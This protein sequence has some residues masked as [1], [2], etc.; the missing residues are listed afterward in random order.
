M[1][2]GDTVATRSRPTITQVEALGLDK[3]GL[4]QVF[5]P[6]Q[7]ENVYTNNWTGPFYGFERVVETFEFTE[8][9]RRLK[10]INLYFHTYLTTKL[11]GMASLDKVFAWIAQ[12]ETTPVH[13]AEYTRKVVEFRHIAVAKTPA[14]WLVR[15]AANTRTL[16]VPVAMGTPDLDASRAVAGYNRNG[17]DQYI[18]LS[19]DEAE[20]VFAP[21][22][23]AP[24]RGP[25]LVSA[26]ARID[27][28]T[29]KG[30]TVSWDFNGH[31]PLQV[32]LANA[33][34]CRVRAGGRDLT[35]TRRD[36]D[37]STYQLSGHAARPLEA[38]CRN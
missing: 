12:Q 35:P 38:I 34:G 14:G 13:V 30:N 5:A 37:L 6:N 31:V 4:F 3:S 25:R 23:S 9:P 26:N 16:R 24:A 32:T 21:S 33:E 36:G 8:K 10:P 1:N 27:A 11:A 22:G 15:G 7:N 18:H 19:G 2:G 20:L 28:S 17:E 29:R